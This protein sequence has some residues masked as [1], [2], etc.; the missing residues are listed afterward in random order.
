MSGSSRETLS[1]E[2]MCDHARCERP[3]DLALTAIFLP[4]GILLLV[5]RL[6]MFLGLPMLAALSPPAWKP[7]LYELLLKS[8]GLRWRWQGLDHLAQIHGQ[9][10]VIAFNHVSLYDALVI[11]TLRNTSLVSS[12]PKTH[13]S[14][15]NVWF[16]GWIV[17]RFGIDYLLLSNKRQIAKTLHAW[18]SE[19]N[20]VTLCVAPEGTVGNGRGL[21]AFKKGF[22]NLGVPVLPLCVSVQSALPI[23][24]HPVLAN[25]A[26]NFLWPFLSPSTRFDLTFL[27]ARTIACGET[28]EEWANSTQRQI[29]DHLGVATTALTGADKQA[30]RRALRA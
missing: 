7:V 12:D 24:A 1:I 3:I 11:A 22:F 13:A 26:W 10:L 4:I 18:R 5:V 6:F 29:A 30:Y 21:F 14:R 19:E 27:P 16:F 28:A 15:A 17:R 2:D 8:L 9:P 20:P 25:H 23:S